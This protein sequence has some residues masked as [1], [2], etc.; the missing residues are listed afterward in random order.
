MNVE[1]AKK[2]TLSLI[3]TFNEAGRVAL[4]L[5]KLG[6]KKKIKPD[7]TPVTNGDLE[8]NKILTKRI[9]KVTPNI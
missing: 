9:A 5:R 4:H 7:K 8:V 2:I 3:E 1:E 6:L